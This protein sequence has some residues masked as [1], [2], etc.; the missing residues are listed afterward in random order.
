MILAGDEF[1]RTQQGNNNGYCQDNEISWVDW[2][3]ID[4]D[5]RAL[6]DFVRRMT[7]IRHAQPLLHRASWRDGMIVTWLNPS[8]GEQTHEQWEDVGANSIALRLS[9]ADL[10]HQDVWSDVV[11]CFNAHDGTVPFV[12]PERAEGVWT[13]VIDTAAPDGPEVVTAGGEIVELAARSLMLF[14]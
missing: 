1:G 10:A 12:L 5:G 4:D 6:T 3:G 8:G 7:A 11:I 9:R 13:S 2:E 14:V